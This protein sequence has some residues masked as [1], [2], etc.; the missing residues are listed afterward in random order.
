MFVNTSGSTAPEWT[1]SGVGI[2]EKIRE[3]AN[4]MDLE[5]YGITHNRSNIPIVATINHAKGNTTINIRSTD[6]N[7]I[8]QLIRDTLSGE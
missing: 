6:A 5:I 7:E 1:L 3:I 8:E 4:E 2:S